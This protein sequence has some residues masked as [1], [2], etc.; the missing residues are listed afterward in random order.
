MKTWQKWALAV[1]LIVLFSVGLPALIAGRLWW[2]LD[3]WSDTLF[4]AVNVV[5]YLVGTAVFPAGKLR[6]QRR[7]LT[8]RLNSVALMAAMVLAVYERA[9]GPAAARGAGWSIAGLALFAA[10]C[11][12]GAA[13]G[14][15][16]GRAYAPNPTI[17]PGQQ[18]VTHGIYRWIR[19]PL[20]TALLLF[21]LG[22]PLILRSLWGAAAG[23]L[24]IVP[25]L[26]LRVRQEEALLVEAF[27]DDYRAYM[28][29]SGRLLPRLYS[30]S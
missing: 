6:E 26:W 7:T 1:P 17:L 22:M 15:A 21:A 13:A 27:G 25:S 29:R 18:L 4:V 2:F 16:L 9:H 14:R 3:S 20:Y 30:R 23:L 28:A 5:M 12:V 11:A 19:H 10:A 8:R 24:I